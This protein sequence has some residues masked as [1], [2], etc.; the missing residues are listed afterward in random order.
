MWKEEGEGRRGKEGTTP[1]YRREGGEEGE[2][3]R[4]RL[5]VGW[6]PRLGRSGFFPSPMR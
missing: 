5:A 4:G 6:S 3:G 1:S 2:R